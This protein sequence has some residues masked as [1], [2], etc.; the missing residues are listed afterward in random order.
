MVSLLLGHLLKALKWS[1]TLV[2]QTAGCHQ[3]DV[4]GLML[5]V[6]SIFDDLAVN[7]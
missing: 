2:P 7:L 3:G 4:N 1:L 6:V 5:P